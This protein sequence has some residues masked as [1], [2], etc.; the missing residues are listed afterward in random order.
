MSKRRVGAE[1]RLVWRISQ[2]DPQGEWVDPGT[3]ETDISE[4]ARDVASGSSWASSSFDLLQGVEVT[5][6]DPDTMPAELYDE[7]FD[8][9]TAGLDGRPKTPPKR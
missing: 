9:H 2:L 7:L 4:A 6:D 1:R 3:V 8:A 5:E